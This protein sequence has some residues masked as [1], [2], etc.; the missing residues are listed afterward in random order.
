ML[1]T[2]LLTILFCLSV[3]SPSVYAENYPDSELMF[4][5]DMVNYAKRY[6]VKSDIKDADLTAGMLT[7]AIEKFDAHSTYYTKDEYNKIVESLSG[8]FSGIGIYIDINQGVIRVIG[9]IKG[10]PAEKAGVKNGDYIIHID[11]KSTFG[12]KLDEASSNLKGKKGTKVIVNI[13]RKDP[14]SA[15][16]KPFELEIT[17]SNIEVE[18]V[19]ATKV[20]DILVITISAFNEKTFDEFHHIIQKNKDYSGIIL[21]LRSNPGGILESAIA[22]S[23]MFLE[24]N[25]IIVQVSNVEKMKKESDQECVAS[26][27]NC[28]KVHYS[29]LSDKIAILNDEEPL[30]SKTIPVAVLVNSYSA[31]ASEITALA[32]QENNRGIVVG[33]K[34]FGKGSVQSIISLPDSEKGAIKLTTALYFSPKGNSIQADGVKPDVVLP[35]LE[36]KKQEKHKDFFPS[37][38]VNYKNHIKVDKKDDKVINSQNKTNDKTDDKGADKN[39]EILEPNAIEDFALQAAMSSIRTSIKYNNNKIQ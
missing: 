38:E 22:V 8:S 37:K 3:I 36:I 18:T 20:G 33:Q 17:R 16:E 4:V 12:M 39:P 34:T 2:I 9:V 1:H 28:R 10:M 31:S 19:V 30:I 32:L 27:K 26:K 23:S 14:E 15:P 25:Q 29:A 13:F 35:E 7:G 24:K 6:A 21:D 11:G 5:R